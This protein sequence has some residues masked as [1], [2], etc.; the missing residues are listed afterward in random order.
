MAK[1]FD[2][3][4]DECV[5][6]INRGDSIEG[7]LADYPGHAGELE[8]M[9]KAMLI[10]QQA[11]EF[12][13]SPVVKDAHRQRFNAALAERRRRQ[14]VGEPLLRRLFGQPKVWAT[15]TVIAVLAV[16]GYFGLRPVLFPAGISPDDGD[17]PGIVSPDDGESTEVII[18]QPSLEGNFVFLIS[19]EVNAIGDFQSVNITISK[20]GL[21]L[22]GDEGQWVEFDPVVAG[23][24]LTLLQGDKAREVWQGDVPLG[25]YNQVFIY[26]DSVTGV[27]TEE[28]GGGV[29]EIK[30]PSSKLHMS[31]AFE[32]TG[33]TAVSFVYDLTVIAAGN[34][35]GGTKYILKPQINESGADQRFE[36]V[37]GH[38]EVNNGDKGQGDGQDKGQGD[39]QDKGM[40][41]NQDKPR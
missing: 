1:T 24:D 33:D 13:P 30:L 10:S 9:L 12:V 14:E 40:D 2:E 11:Y 20:I 41:K 29:V 18:A 28:K 35:Q 34:A 25:Q 37:N 6:R 32:V 36:L 27:L 16:A 17:G 5:D 38:G 21:K 31:K 19:D 26:V 22:G 3:I 15:V 39:G 8:P 7:C 23:V 4:F